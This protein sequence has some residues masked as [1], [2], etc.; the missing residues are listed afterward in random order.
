M[1]IILYLVIMHLQQETETNMKQG[2]K[3][4]RT[5]DYI[6]SK[7]VFSVVQQKSFIGYL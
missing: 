6:F 4:S 1:H 2:Q 7:H 5:N 3:D